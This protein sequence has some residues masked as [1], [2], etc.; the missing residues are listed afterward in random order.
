MAIRL[1]LVEKNRN[2]FCESKFWGDPDM[3]ADME[4]PMLGGR[5]LTFL[6]QVDCYD[7]APLDTEGILPHEGMFYFFA[8][9]D[10]LL[11][12]DTG[13]CHEA[14]EWPKGHSLVKFSKTVNMETF[15]SMVLDSYWNNNSSPIIQSVNINNI[16]AL[17]NK[18]M[19]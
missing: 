15:K 19:A 16:I 18:A 10:D 1:D 11:G 7:I 9:I 17:H 5:P 6:C 3:P 4:Y 12:Y 13:V 2:L 8:D 14:G